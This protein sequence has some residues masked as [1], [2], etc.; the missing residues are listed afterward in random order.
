LSTFERSPENV[1]KELGGFA[2]SLTSG[3]AK[4]PPLARSGIIKETYIHN[5]HRQVQEKNEN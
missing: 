2:R 1:N 5:A 3:C 4:L